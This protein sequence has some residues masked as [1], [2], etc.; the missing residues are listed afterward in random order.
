MADTAAVVGGGIGGLAT[1]IALHRNGWRVVVYERAPEIPATGTALGMWP[2]A[3]HAL[4]A[5]GVGDDVRRLGQRQRVGEFRRPDGTRIAAIDTAKLERRTGD[6]VYLLS[7]PALLNLLRRAVGDAALH[8][9]TAVREL[10]PLREKFD[11]VVAADG[12]F[13]QAREEAF[14]PDYRARYAGNTAWRGFVEDLPTETFT[15]TWG[16]GAKFGVTPQEGGRTNWYASIP[17]PEGGFTPGAELAN[18]RRL[19][20]GWADPV[21]TVLD[22][23]SEP[24]ILR[25]D[26]YVTPRLPTFVRHNVAF[27]GDAAHAMRPDLGRGACEALIDAITLATCLRDASAIPHG[28]HAYD[29][30]RRRPAQRLA[31]MSGVAAG[32][33]RIRHALWLR[34]ALLRASMLAGP[35][36]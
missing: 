23:I 13:S 27:I 16:D 21:R 3:L 20:G 1:A 31:G 33:S 35:P 7:R 25:H 4:D 32:L 36:G 11:V 15:E 28:L 34:D 22:A 12:V 8:L 10:R 18:L 14:G 26:V 5:L 19:F 17:A 30:Q 9:G 2:A 24:Q 29:R 6:P